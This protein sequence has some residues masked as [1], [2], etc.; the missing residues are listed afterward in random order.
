MLLGAVAV[1]P[2]FL[3]TTNR[4]RLPQRAQPCSHAPGFYRRSVFGAGRDSRH[5]P[6]DCFRLLAGST[7]PPFW[8]AWITVLED[9]VAKRVGVE[10]TCAEREDAIEALRFELGLQQPEQAYDWT[11]RNGRSPKV[12]SEWATETVRRR[13]LQIA[14]TPELRAALGTL[15]VRHKSMME[16]LIRFSRAP[17]ENTQPMTREEADDLMDFYRQATG[18]SVVAPL[19]LHVERLGFCSIRDFAEALRRTHRGQHDNKTGRASL[20][21]EISI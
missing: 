1:V 18:E 12:L 17:Q 19:R 8:S 11:T 14:L 7:L 13:K 10:V 9:L 15:A 3:A 2:V 6:I 20:S 21:Q 16:R 4:I 5:C